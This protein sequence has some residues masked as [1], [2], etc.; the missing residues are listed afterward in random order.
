MNTWRRRKTRKLTNWL[1]N[2]GFNSNPIKPIDSS[3]T[4]S[5]RL[6]FPCS[7]SFHVFRFLLLIL[8]LLI[9]RRGNRTAQWL[10]FLLI[11]YKSYINGP[12]CFIQVN[13]TFPYFSI[14]FDHP[15]LLG[16]TYAK[17]PTNKTRVVLYDHV[18]DQREATTDH[19][20]HSRRSHNQGVMS[21]FSH[22]SPSYLLT[23]TLSTLTLINITLQISVNDILALQ[24]HLNSFKEL[25]LTI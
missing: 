17:W 14:M 18:T 22:L 24:Y 15:F 2:F 9:D 1:I 21:R 6:K 23:W 16:T 25:F 4:L 11:D 10:I 13:T 3:H 20:I 8:L 12:T 19:L 7:T 5:S